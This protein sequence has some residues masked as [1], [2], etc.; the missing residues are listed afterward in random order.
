MRFLIQFARVGIIPREKFVPCA[1]AALFTV[2]IA[3]FG[4]LISA[5]S[6][7][8]GTA[9]TG[10]TCSTS[11]ARPSIADNAGHLID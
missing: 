7:R 5:M 9:E 6:L 1:A 4:A 11:D 3:L 10:G 2:W 8:E